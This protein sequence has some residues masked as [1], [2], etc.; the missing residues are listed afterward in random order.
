MIYDNG[1]PVKPQELEKIINEAVEKA[2]EQPVERAVE[3]ALAH[4]FQL[5]GL[6]IQEPKEQLEAQ[7]D[8]TFLRSLRRAVDGTAAAVGKTIVTALIAGTLSLL[9]MAFNTKR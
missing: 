5:L 8:L 4:Q 1:K 2:V 7:K 3:K 6:L 9:W